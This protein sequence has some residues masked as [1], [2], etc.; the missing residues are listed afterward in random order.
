MLT[1]KMEE[2]IDMLEQRNALLHRELRCLLSNIDIDGDTGSNNPQ[3]FNSNQNSQR[4]ESQQ[5][6]SSMEI[7]I[8][9]A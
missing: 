5:S 4:V 2:T 6:R 7:P 1:S 8:N 3:G 9:V